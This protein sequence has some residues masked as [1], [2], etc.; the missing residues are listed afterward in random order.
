MQYSLVLELVALV[1]NSMSLVAGLILMP[2]K[3]LLSIPFKNWSVHDKLVVVVLTAHTIQELCLL[4]DDIICINGIFKKVPSYDETLLLSPVTRFSSP[5]F[6]EIIMIC[7]PLLSAWKFRRFYNVNIHKRIFFDRIVFT[8]LC[9]IFI[10][11]SCV[12]AIYI[13]TDIVHFDLNVPWLRFL[14]FMLGCGTVVTNSIFCEMSTFLV[15]LTSVCKN[16]KNPKAA[17]FIIEKLKLTAYA[18][19]VYTLI[20]LSLVVV[21]EFVAR[22]FMNALYKIGFAMTLGC[23]YIVIHMSWVLYDSLLEIKAVASKQNVKKMHRTQELSSI[24]EFADGETSDGHNTFSLLPTLL[25]WF[26]W[27]ASPNRQDNIDLEAFAS[28]IE[29]SRLNFSR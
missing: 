28:E 10:F 17:R 22:D 6:F 9:L 29:S 1:F 7:C 24:S 5:L 8:N 26:H 18:S 19:T 27:P 20:L 25:S 3:I 11:M 12:S 16:Q 23:T 15:V 13:L 21:L 4:A 14:A 2:W